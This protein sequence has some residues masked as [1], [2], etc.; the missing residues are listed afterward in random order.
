M[1]AQCGAASV[2]AFPHEKHGP[3]ECNA[4]VRKTFLLMVGFVG[5]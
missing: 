5:V 2:N 4:A 3:S 1:E